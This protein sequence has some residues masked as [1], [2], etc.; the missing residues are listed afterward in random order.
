VEP[1]LKTERN[2]YKI[3]FKP[4]LSSLGFEVVISVP[5]KFKK[6]QK[7]S[8]WKCSFVFEKFP[9]FPISIFFYLI[10]MKDL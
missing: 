6:I 10:S 7:I 2:Y 3:I 1:W 5:E 4:S 9:T 8:E